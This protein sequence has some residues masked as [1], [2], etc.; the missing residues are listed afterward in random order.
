MKYPDDFGGFTWNIMPAPV[1]LLPAVAVS[2]VAIAEAEVEEPRGLLVNTT[3]AAPGYVLFSPL[4]SGTTYLIDADGMVVHTW[5]TTHAPGASVYLMDNGNLLRTAR[6]WDVPVFK[7]G[8]QGGRIQEFTWE[9]DL[10]WDFLLATEERLLH[11]DIERLPNGNVLAI[12]WE[13]KSVEEVLAVGR[14]PDLVPEKGLW[15]DLVVELE[16]L[17]PSPLMSIRCGTIDGSP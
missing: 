13:P 12:A 10:V 11:H 16:P 5:Q 7:G 3:A 14:R 6:E 1:E 4:L 8:G 17:P 15:P 2:P 9:G